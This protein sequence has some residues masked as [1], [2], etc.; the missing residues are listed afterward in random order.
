M[1]APLLVAENVSKTYRMGSVDV[2]ALSDVSVSLDA[3]EFVSLTG[4]SGSGKS[5]LLNVFSGLA[6]ANSGRVRIEGS[7]LSE[8]RDAA[9]AAFLAGTCGYVFQRFNLIDVLSAQENVEFPLWQLPMSRAERQERAAEM[10]DR[11][12]LGDRRHHRPAQLSGG[13]QQRVSIARALVRTPKILFADEPT[14]NL[15]ATSSEQIMG[16][17]QDLNATND[18]LCVISTHDP[19]IVAYTK[20]TIQLLDGKVVQ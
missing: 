20:R 1:S 8:M 5:T 2:P 13:Q 3:G 15:D 9:R 18:C 12:G 10:L 16:L 4:P 6:R 19:E 11:V 17:F 14:A 7:D